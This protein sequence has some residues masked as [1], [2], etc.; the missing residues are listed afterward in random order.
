[1]SDLAQIQGVEHE[2]LLTLCNSR[3]YKDSLYLFYEYFPESESILSFFEVKKGE[4]RGEEGG[5]EG[6][7]VGIMIVLC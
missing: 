7:F 2:N 4:G 1:M 6:F 3:C 5:G